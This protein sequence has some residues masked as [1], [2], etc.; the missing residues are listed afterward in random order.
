MTQRKVRLLLVEDTP[1]VR[2][3]MLHVLQRQPGL[4]VLESASDGA[5]AVEAVQRL[6]P[7]VVVMDVH[8]PVMDGFEATRR[9]MQDNPVPIVIV[10]G[11]VEDIVAARFKALEAGAL[12]FLPRPRGI[13]HPCHIREVAEL[14]RTVLLMSEVKVVRR[15]MRMP[16]PYMHTAASAFVP[17]QVVAIGAS[18]GGPP[19]IQALLQE[20]P[21]DFSAPVLIVQ[22]IAEGFLEGFVAWIGRTSVL[23]VHL[24]VDAE[25]A[26]PGH[27]Y[28]A[29]DRRHMGVAAGGRIALTDG[30]HDGGLRPSVTHLMRSLPRV[31]RS[32]VAAVLLSG[33]GRDGTAELL[34]LRRGGA[35]TFVQDRASSVVYG[36]PGVALG[37]DAAQHV[38]APAD[39]GR[40]LAAIGRNGVCGPNGRSA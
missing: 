30:P 2:A 38:M 25:L 22:H 3:F 18:T 4:D 12:A 20:L 15:R 13:G 16:V 37:L 8:M 7:D 28:V 32:G 34:M 26:L 31:Y 9:I 29:P 27:I 35:R 17:L 21:A 14:A 1:V 5:Q 39:I 19:A 33:M 36:M 11:A 40:E 23:P 6:H 10:S 24:A